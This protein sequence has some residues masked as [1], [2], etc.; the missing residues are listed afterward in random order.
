MKKQ[1][2]NTLINLI[3]KNSFT[4]VKIN[5]QDKRGITLIALVVTIVVL[6]ILAGVTITMV[7]GED[8]ILAQAKLAAEKTKEAEEN[9]RAQIEE[10]GDII[11][12]YLKVPETIEEA[13]KIN[14]KF[15]ENTDITD[16]YGNP[17]TIPAGFRIVPNGTDYV[18]YN[19]DED[20]NGNKTHIPTVQDGI[21]IKDEENY[22]VWIPVGKIK[23]KENDTEKETNIILGRYKFDVTVTGKPGF[24][25][26]QKIDGTGKAELVQ[27]AQNY[28]DTSDNTKIQHVF[29]ANANI[30]YQ[31]LISTEEND[32]TYKNVKAKNL[33]EFISNTNEKGGYY[34][35]RYEAVKGEDEKVKSKQS[36]ADTAKSAD[37]EILAGTVWINLTQS[38]AAE[39]SRIMYEEN[40]N[41]ETDLMNSYSWDTAIVFI[42]KY[43][44]KIEYSM[45]VSILGNGT[46][47]TGERIDKSTDKECNIYDLASNLLEWSTETCVTI[48]N[49]DVRRGGHA[50]NVASLTCTRS[51]DNHDFTDI[52]R[53]FRTI[54]YIK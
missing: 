38:N 1:K 5:L 4:R 28:L 18:E 27:N 41:F 23:N 11:N 30:Y 42:Q 3:Q 24:P 33:S 13:I 19:Y 26:E 25:A 51:H 37:E 31:E 17:I 34:I 2:K 44:G 47:R 10:I 45:H 36:T 9:A 15:K 40:Q 22:F 53:S 35:A 50:E 54:L 29:D 12:D 6:L 46:R 16:K 8:G 39:V 21:V 43:T 7:V 20:E 49:A 52:Y 14:Y 48:P 32:T